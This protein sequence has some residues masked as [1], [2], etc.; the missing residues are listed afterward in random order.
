M[1]QLVNVQLAIDRVHTVQRRALDCG[2]D[3]GTGRLNQVMGPT[4]PL[5]L[6]KTGF[7]LLWWHKIPCIFKVISRSIWLWISVCVDNI[8]MTKM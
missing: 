3:L 6:L 1:E 7:P 4:V 2:P 5:P 8:D